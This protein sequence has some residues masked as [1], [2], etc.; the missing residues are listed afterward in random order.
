M[1]NSYVA[2]VLFSVN[3]EECINYEVYI[4]VTLT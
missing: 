3:L 2:N 4:L 1:F